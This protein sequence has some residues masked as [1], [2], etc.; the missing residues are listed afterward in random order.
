MQRRFINFNIP[1]D[2]QQMNTLT[3]ARIRSIDLLRGLIMII[4]ALDH[5]REYFHSDAFLFDPLD[6]Q[7][8]SVLLFFTRWITHFCAPIFVLLAGV[9]ARISGQRKTK[10][11]LAVFL[12]KRGFWLIFLEITVVNF[13]WFFNIHFSFILLAVIWALGCCMIFLAALI[14]LPKKILLPLGILLIVAHNL[15]DKIHFQGNNLTGFI[16]SFFHDQNLFTVGHFKILVAYPLLPYIGVMTLGY[17]L[18]EVYT[19]GVD[20]YK[21]KQILLSIGSFCLL[22]FFILRSGNYYGDPAGWSKQ[23]TF[24]FSF[25]SF[26]KVTKY[27]PSLDY[28]LITEGFALIFLA[29]TETISNSLTKFISVYGRVPM[30]YYILHIYL[31]HFFALVAITFT[32]RPWTQ[33][34]GFD[35]WIDYISGMKGYG[36]SL[37]TVYLV[38]ISIVLLLYPLCKKY[39]RYKASH[40][41]KWWLSYL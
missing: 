8:T 10:K 17:C 29:L 22:L 37:G 9:S 16:W 32:G 38:W 19:A 28:L 14:F 41:N 35:N 13:S 25:L 3:T 11:E 1:N 34:T 12:V 23:P 33:M 30:F 31:I 18:G 21:R 6:L 40:R 39:D 4:M 24:T 5:T 2:F 26:I 7:K 27:P 36:F 15:L 20:P